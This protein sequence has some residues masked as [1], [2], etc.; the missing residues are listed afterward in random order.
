MVAHRVAYEYFLGP[1]PPGME[2]DHLC[3][4][5]LCVNPM[6]LEVV[7]HRENVARR[8]RRFMDHGKRRAV[9]LPPEDRHAREMLRLGQIRDR[10]F[11]RLAQRRNGCWIWTA[12]KVAGYGLGY[13][14]LTVPTKGA[15]AH[16]IAFEYFIG[17]IPK[18]RELDHLC[19]N[20]ACCNPTHLELVTR[21]ENTKRANDARTH[22]N[23]GHAFTK[24]NSVTRK[25]SRAC[26]KC[27]R[28]RAMNYYWRKVGKFDNVIPVGSYRRR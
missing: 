10:F 26:L 28:I 1:I 21:G 16:R 20:R 9:T 25:G 22:C 12:A 3:R 6:H 4:T 7:G 24:R 8:D 14:W 18:G 2:V 5:R 11:A 15:Y 27:I 17:S 23:N 19:R 13:S